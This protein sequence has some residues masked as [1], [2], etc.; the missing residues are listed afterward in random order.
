MEF[1]ITIPDDMPQDK[2][3][4]FTN[5]ITEIKKKILFFNAIKDISFVNQADYTVNSMGNIELK[6]EFTNEPAIVQR[7]IQNAVDNILYSTMFSVYKTNGGFI[8]I[9]DGVDNLNELNTLLNQ[10]PK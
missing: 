9:I 7:C 5:L 8:M 4:Y 2:L 1:S 10:A 6:L 3:I